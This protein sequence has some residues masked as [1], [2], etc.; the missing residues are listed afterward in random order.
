MEMPGQIVRLCRSGGLCEIRTRET[1]VRWGELKSATLS[2]LATRWQ[3][4]EATLVSYKVAQNPDRK[5]LPCP[6][7]TFCESS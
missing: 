1:V 3:L 4:R 5:C 2:L 7:N 6:E